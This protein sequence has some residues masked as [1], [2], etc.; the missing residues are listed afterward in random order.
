MWNDRD[1]STRLGNQAQIEIAVC[2]WSCIVI[3]CVGCITLR[4]LCVH[5]ILAEV[6][7]KSTFGII[8]AISIEINHRPDVA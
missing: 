7:Y 3:T 2:D 5:H 4:I 8:H 6:G 1:I